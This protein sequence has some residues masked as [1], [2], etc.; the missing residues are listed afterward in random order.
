MRALRPIQSVQLCQYSYEEVFFGFD[1]VKSHIFYLRLVRCLHCKN[2]SEPIRKYRFTYSLGM[3]IVSFLPGCEPSCCHDGSC[4][5][6]R[7]HGRVVKN[8][9]TKISRKTGEHPWKVG[10]LRLSLI[11]SVKVELDHRDHTWGI[12]FYS[13]RNELLIG[14][15]DKEKYCNQ[16]K[17]YWDACLPGLVSSSC[18]IAGRLLISVVSSQYWCST[19]NGRPQLFAWHWSWKHLAHQARQFKFLLLLAGT[20]GTSLWLFPGIQMSVSNLERD[21]RELTVVL[22]MHEVG[23]SANSVFVEHGHEQH[24]GVRWNGGDRCDTTNMPHL[25]CMIWR[26]HWRWDMVLSW[27]SI[28]SVRYW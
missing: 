7:R 20:E 26:I 1:H 21:K 27:V 18:R 23:I 6:Y 11:N 22:K 19:S 9:S 12:G 13:P 14:S 16:W 25:E 17:V 5:G 4:T 3:M 28:V 10:Q 2:L 15:L 8:G 24:A